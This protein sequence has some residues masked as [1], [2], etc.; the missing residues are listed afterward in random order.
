MT[1][2]VAATTEHER[3]CTLEHAFVWLLVTFLPCSCSTHSTVLHV[4]DFG[5]LV[6]LVL[7]FSYSSVISRFSAIRMGRNK[8]NDE[9][10]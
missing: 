10:D 8:R 5:M 2:Q 1:D 4:R 3:V 6:V 7:C 9:P